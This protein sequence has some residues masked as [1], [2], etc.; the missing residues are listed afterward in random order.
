VE[1]ILEICQIQYFLFN[2]TPKGKLIFSSNYFGGETEFTYKIY[3]LSGQIVSGGITRHC[4]ESLSSL[5]RD[6]GT[7][8]VSV[9]DLPAGYYT[10]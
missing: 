9:A 10:I 6:I 2:Q 8:E 4:F 1:V 3:F 7:I 5:S